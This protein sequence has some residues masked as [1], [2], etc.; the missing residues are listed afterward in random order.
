[1]DKEKKLPERLITLLGN[2]K[3][4]LDN[5]GCSDSSIIIFSD[6]VLKIEKQSEESDNEHKMYQWLQGKLP[7]PKVYEGFCEEG[8]NYLLMSRL[9]GEM[10]CSKNN[11]SRPDKVISYLVSGLKKLW[12]VAI[13]ELPYVYV[14]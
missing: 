3:Y 10:V 13:S 11:L 1:M 2:E 14:P 4:E 8:Y 6:K 12:S 7:I 5:I 9:N